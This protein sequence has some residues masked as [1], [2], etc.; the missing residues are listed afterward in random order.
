[1]TLEDL[2][3]LTPAQLKAW[4]QIEFGVKA[5]KKAGGE[6]YTVLETVSGYNGK[7]VDEIIGDER[8]SRYPTAD[9]HMHSI[10]DVGLACFA[11]DTHFI[12]LTDK[13][14]ALIEG[15]E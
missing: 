10:F 13:G 8:E 5:F 4:K 14:E 3:E 1:M 9:A 7:Y 11:D 2:L 6:F 15:D 12:H